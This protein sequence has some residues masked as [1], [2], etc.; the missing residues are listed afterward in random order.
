[1]RD[2]SIICMDRT[3]PA[4]VDGGHIGLEELVVIVVSVPVDVVVTDV[5]LLPL[6]LLWL[7]VPILSILV[8]PVI[9]SL[10]PSVDVM[11]VDFKGN[12]GNRATCSLL[13]MGDCRIAL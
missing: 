7:S 1:M 9:G 5:E 12:G 4:K 2:D 10:L 11:D 13:R 6:S 8:R 3:R